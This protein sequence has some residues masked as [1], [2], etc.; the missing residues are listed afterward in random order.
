MNRD[1][2]VVYAQEFHSEWQE[3]FEQESATPDGTLQTIGMNYFLKPQHN[4]NTDP[5]DKTD[6]ITTT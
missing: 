3:V 4:V 2:I 6:V 1:A 5:A